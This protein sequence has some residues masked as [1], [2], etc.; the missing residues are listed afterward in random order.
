[1]GS[2]GTRAN[3][4]PDICTGCPAAAAAAAC[5]GIWWVTRP[6]ISSVCSGHCS[7]CS[8]R[9][10]STCCCGRVSRGVRCRC[11]RGCSWAHPAQQEEEARVL[12]TPTDGQYWACASHC[13]H[14]AARGSAAACSSFELM[15][16]LKIHPAGG[17]VCYVLGVAWS[18][19]KSSGAMRMARWRQ[20]V[21]GGSPAVLQS[22]GWCSVEDPGVLAAQQL[23][24][25]AGS[26]L[27]LFS[28]SCLGVARLFTALSAFH[29]MLGF[30]R[31]F[32]D[33]HCWCSSVPNW[34]RLLR[35][36]S[37]VTTVIMHCKL[38]SS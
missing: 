6:A 25:A 12:S 9:S 14:A 37:A 21:G 34:P 11:G 33:S 4:C 17:L 28:A 20:R 36:S 22:S 8:S 23:H 30:C 16:W 32:S 35:C 1:M 18:A 29:C 13:W 19:C 2:R 3:G 27:A 5:A 31:G 26:G 7:Q 24:A 10:S 15:N 38:A